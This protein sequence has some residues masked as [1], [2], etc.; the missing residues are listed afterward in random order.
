SVPMFLF[1]LP[2]GALAD[3]LD[4]RRLLLAVV[5]ASMCVST[6]IA[7]LVSLDLV[8]PPVLLFFTFLLGAAAALT[9]PAW[10]AIVPSL[11]PRPVLPPA[12]AANS[13]GINISRAVG[14]ALG[15]LII[16]AFG[17]AMPFW[18]NALSNIGIIAALLWWRSPPRP[19][20]RLPA[21]RFA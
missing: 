11:V 19:A 1:A 4:K 20:H 3:I 10:Q 15:G 9:A 17:I 6:A 16:A 13:L 5:I 14:P 18:L 7:A 8:S 12:V 2:A 21:E